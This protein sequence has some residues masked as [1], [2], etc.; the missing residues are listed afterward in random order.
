MLNRNTQP[1]IIDATDFNLH[2]KPYEYFT[3]DN[4]IAVYA[5]RAPEQ[6]VAYAEWVFFAGNAYEQE[7]MTAS[8]VNYLI[9]NGTKNKTAFE[10]NE[11]FEFY[12]SYINRN[13]YNETSSVKLHC[14]SKYLPELLPMVTELL[15]ES[16]FP[17][18]ELAIYK[19]NQKQNLEVNLKKCDFIANRLIDEYLF[20][21]AHPY[22]RYASMVDYDNLERSRLIHFYDDYY[23]N[24]KCILFVAGN[25]PGNI[26][27][28]LNENFG[29]LLCNNQ[30]AEKIQYKINPEKKKE[31]FII[32]DENGVQG[33]VRV[34]RNFP[35]RHHPDFIK[36]QVLNNILG[37]YF[38]S[39]LMSNIREDKGY[40]YGIHS[41]LQNHIHESAWMIST[42]AGR[43]VCE[44]T[45]NEVFKEMQ[46]L[47]EVAVE[48]EELHLVR[49][50]M[51]GGLL[52]DLDGPFQTILRWKNYI[53][54]NLKEDYFD[55]SIST[56]KNITAAELQELANKY[57]QPD[58]FYKLTVI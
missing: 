37:G 22:G 7:N 18:E 50:H 21:F 20:G 24:G 42:E 26:E 43:D 49:N 5:L 57:L 51:I 14:L 9:K 15:T 11:Y 30:E 44:A 8:S 36:A 35:N 13:C 33:A 23:I 32:N 4:G 55:N 10:I 45:I 47:R 17:E 12:G 27:T 25:L 19:Q 31:H 53:L 2:L 40:T 28:L 38:G 16:V 6:E 41:Y 1:A 29:S 48:E 58:A 3:L 39:R 34:A 56:I 52:G 54:N 46:H